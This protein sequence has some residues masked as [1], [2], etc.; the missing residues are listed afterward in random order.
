MKI[1]PHSSSDIL[2]LETEFRQ[3]FQFG[4]NVHVT[5]TFQR[6][7]AEWEEYIDL[8]EDTALNDKEKLKVIVTPTLTTPSMSPPS[9]ATVMTPVDEVGHT[10]YI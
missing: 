4:S 1:P 2:Y 7:D 10:L 8:E 6:Y 9:V 5:I 3:L